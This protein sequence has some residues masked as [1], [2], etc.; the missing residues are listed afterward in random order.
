MFDYELQEIVRRDLRLDKYARRV[1]VADP[2]QVRRTAAYKRA[3]SPAGPGHQLNAGEIERAADDSAAWIRIE[4]VEESV[5]S[6][7]RD[8]TLRQIGGAS[9]AERFV[10][11]RL[12]DDF[13]RGGWTG[14]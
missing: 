5:R 11:E 1:S 3:S 13:D 8:W 10:V 12:I 2:Y 14:I 9:P 7:L 6:W 4:D